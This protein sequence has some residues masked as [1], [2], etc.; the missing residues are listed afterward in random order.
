M[1]QPVTYILLFLLVAL[2]APLSRAQELNCIVSVVSPKN[3]N[4]DPRVFKN[5]E[6]AIMEFMNGRKWSG[7]TYKEFERIECSIII[8]ITD[9]P[10]EGV[11]RASAIINAQRPV[12]NSNYNSVL[13][14]Y[15]D[16][17][18]DFN[19]QDLQILDYNDNGYSANLTSL[20]AYYAYLILAYDGESFASEGGSSF[21]LK[22][23]NVMNNVPANERS[24]YKGW[25]K[26][27]G[28]RNRFVLVDSW[29]NPRYK[30]VRKAYFMY[31]YNGLDKMYDDA[32]SA[33][34]MITASLSLLQN[35][36][37]D[38]PALMPLRI[39]FESKREEL[40]NI[41]S[42]ADMMEKNMI[43]TLL[44]TLDPINSDNYKKILK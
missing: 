15:Q 33:R 20:L 36:N 12:Y 44:G 27:D 13:F 40:V 3:Q 1:K 23:L 38:N 9:I 8:N 6:T 29:L 10:K 30:D 25:S 26:L 31:H 18:F 2:A 16:K 22:A 39:F 5:L 41:Y 7:D 19:Y 24:V 4:I 11:Y 35:V 43:V 28:Q 42:K 14:N 37:L 21:F 32:A 34:S 17:E